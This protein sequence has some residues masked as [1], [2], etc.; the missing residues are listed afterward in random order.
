MENN[1]KL[2]DEKQ[3]Y[4]Q[5]INAIKALKSQADVLGNKIRELHENIFGEDETA[6]SKGLKHDL[7]NAYQ[8]TQAKLKTLKEDFAAI[9]RT[10]VSAFPV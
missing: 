3:N 4:T 5:T 8:D 2:A 1:K 7:E 10:V 6:N 9:S